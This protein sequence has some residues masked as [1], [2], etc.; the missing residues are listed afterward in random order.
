MNPGGRATAYL[1]GR[2]TTRNTQRNSFSGREGFAIAVELLEAECAGAV[3][4]IVAVFASSL[5]QMDVSVYSLG[6]FSSTHP[7][8][9]Q[10]RVCRR[11]PGADARRSE[12]NP[13]ADRSRVCRRTE[14]GLHSRRRQT[15]KPPPVISCSGIKQPTK[16]VEPECG[17]SLAPGSER[18]RCTLLKLGST[19]AWFHR[20]E[21][22]LRTSSSLDRT[23]FLHHVVAIQTI[24]FVLEIHFPLMSS[25]IF[26]PI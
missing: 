24:Y 18:S 6:S 20:A 8:R 22:E 12:T 5:L 25:E 16:A 14:R 13:S 21:A 17:C 26:T 23:L 3:I 19:H 11:G 4:A 7:A 2:L 9:W 10:R 15:A 1:V